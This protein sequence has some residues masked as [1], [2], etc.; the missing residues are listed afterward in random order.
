MRARHLFAEV[1]FSELISVSH[2]SVINSVIQI[3]SREGSGSATTISARSD[4]SIRKRKEAAASAIIVHYRHSSLAAKFSVV[5]AANSTRLV[6][7]A[8]K[9]AEERVRLSSFRPYLTPFAQ[10]IKSFWFKTSKPYEHITT[11][12]PPGVEIT[13]NQDL[14][15]IDTS[16][17]FD[18]KF[19]ISQEGKRRYLLF[20]ISFLCARRSAAKKI[21]KKKKKTR[22]PYGHFAIERYRMIPRTARCSTDINSRYRY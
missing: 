10:R 22:F 15:Q 3:R 4:P 18:W 1:T 14:N 19:T 16:G 20:S 9:M 12:P 7:A 2:D 21:T 6:D 11:E 13:A 17:T 8:I 5:A